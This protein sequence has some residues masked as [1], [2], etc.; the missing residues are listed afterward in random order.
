MA[1]PP[2]TPAEPSPVTARTLG[3]V[4]F[5]PIRSA[6]ASTISLNDTYVSAEIH[7][8]IQ[9]VP[10]RVGDEIDA[11]ALLARLDCDEHTLDLQQARAMTQAAR[12]DAEFARFQLER[13]Q[14]LAR[15][16]AVSAEVLNER[17]AQSA[18]SRA[19]VLRLEAAS[20]SAQRR[21]NHCEIR[22]PF[23]AV[24]IERLASTGELVQ[25]GTPIAR[26]L[27]AQELEVSGNIQQQDLPALQAAGEV[28]FVA[29]GVHY[30]IALRAISPIVDERLRSVDVRFVF[31]EEA[32]RPGQVGR[33]EWVSEQRHAPADLL[34]R[35]DDQLGIFL[36][37]DGSARFIATPGVR[38]GQ[39][40]PLGLSGEARLIIDGRF[41]L[42]DGDAVRVVTR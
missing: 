5:H 38:E 35:R 36:E 25:A 11:G 2:A 31:Q 29:A 24:V 33:I 34:V 6:P 3:E 10:V 28:R 17:Q 4:G 42:R 13:A 18:R 1:V 8:V 22:A 7:G 12:A 27:D 23:D 16:Q 19:E 26:I 40:P 32:A 39:P 20:R 14:E 15:R 21:V 30:P 37:E 41:G 9:E